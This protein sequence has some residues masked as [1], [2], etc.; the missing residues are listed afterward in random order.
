MLLRQKA[1]DQFLFLV[2]ERKHDCSCHAK[3]LALNFWWP[4]TNKIIGTQHHQKL[5]LHSSCHVSRVLVVA[6]K[7]EHGTIRVGNKRLLMIFNALITTTVTQRA[8]I[9]HYG[10][11][12]CLLHWIIQSSIHLS[13]PWFVNSHPALHITILVINGALIEITVTQRAM[14]CH[15]R[16]Y[17]CLLHWMIQSL[18]QLSCPRFVNSY[19]ALHT[20][21]RMSCK[22]LQYLVRLHLILKYNAT[23]VHK[24]WKSQYLWT[25]GWCV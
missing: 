20:I 19:P 21:Q 9:F 10:W 3:K 23:T 22:L 8:M 5:T 2:R 4:S 18:I 13:C 6:T 17:L 15:S 12:M 1:R 16:W 7:L 25:H 24:E 14:S 11:Y